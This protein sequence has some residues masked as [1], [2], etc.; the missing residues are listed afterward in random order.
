MSLTRR[1]ALGISWWAWLLGAAGCAGLPWGAGG[2][3]PTRSTAGALVRTFDRGSLAGASER[4]AAQV[5]ESWARGVPLAPSEDELDVDWSAWSLVPGT[6]RLVLEPTRPALQAQNVE[7]ALSVVVPLAAAEHEIELS[8]ADLDVPCRAWAATTP[9]ELTVPMSFVTDKLGRVQGIVLPGASYRALSEYTPTLVLDAEAAS[10]TGLA[11]IVRPHVLA[12]LFAA[13]AAK[14]LGES[15]SVELPIALGLDLA[16][17]WSTAVSADALGTGF[18]R[19]ALRGVAGGLVRTRGATVQVAY[20]LTMEADAHP[21]MGPLTLPEPRAELATSELPAGAALHIEALERVVGAAW[22]AGAVCADHLGAIPVSADGLASAWPALAALLPE[23]ELSLEIWPAALPR[24]KADADHVDGLVLETGRLRADLIV[25]FAGARWRA[26]SIEL[27]LSLHGNLW[28]EVDGAVY[29]D[30]MQ[31]DVRP[32]AIE[33]GLL[34]APDLAATALLVPPLV[35]ALVIDRVF[36]QL[37][38][39]LAPATAGGLAVDGT[40]LLWTPGAAR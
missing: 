1:S 5:A 8:G 33:P 18:A 14:A 9:G 37:P 19:V 39:V 40:L 24:L 28:V 2:A 31:I 27:D 25:T 13:G 4:L 35:E 20:G 12:E 10:C 34:D 23:A 30:P 15:L 22:L 26:A 38:P 6:P 11:D 16:F 17:A 36:A 29:F 32:I 21:C 7:L 3:E